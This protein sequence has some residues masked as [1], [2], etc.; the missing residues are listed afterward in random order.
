MFGYALRRLTQ[1]LFVIVGVSVVVFLLIH[2]APGDPALLML[3]EGASQQE[4]DQLR[5][6]LG[7]DRPWLEQYGLFVWRAAHGDLGTSFHY[8]RP[9][10]QIVLEFLPETLYLS[11]AALLL[12]LAVSLPLGVLSALRRNSPWDFLGMSFAV[13]GQ[14]M[15]PF[16]LG[17]MLIFLFAVRLRWFP[18]SGSG[19]IAHTILPAVTLSAYLMA[20][21]TRL[22]RSGLLEVMDQDY[23]RTARSKGLATQ[24]VVGKHALRNTLI[25]L[26]TVI[27]LQ[28]G[29]LIA[30]AIVVETVFSWPGVGR[31]LIQSI[32]ARDYPVIQSAVLV[33]SV[34]VVVVNLVVDVLYAFIDPRISYA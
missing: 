16:W 32:N 24:T 30:G 17:I 22:V 8:E 12:A 11:F 34:F 23:V 26:V 21:L 18:T 19:G 28:L 25:P 2:L 6:Q 5:G 4:V 20:L 3:R 7:L 27:G 33:I 15:P 31:L 13:L 1:G 10:I 9:A 14:A 29:A